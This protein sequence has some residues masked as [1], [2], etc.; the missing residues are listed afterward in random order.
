MTE[1]LMVVCGSS[2]SGRLSIRHDGR[3]RLIEKVGNIVQLA[4]TDWTWACVIAGLGDKARCWLITQGDVHQS[5]GKHPFHVAGSFSIVVHTNNARR[6]R[7]M[8][9]ST[10]PKGTQNESED[11]K[12]EKGSP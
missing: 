12:A 3:S 11:Q 10:K 5:I 7:Y 4:I 2:E 1:P 8:F 9:S 6:A